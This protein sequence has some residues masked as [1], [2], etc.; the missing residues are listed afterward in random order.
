MNIKEINQL[1]EN[2][3]EGNKG[4]VS[5]GSHTFDELYFHRMTLFAVICNSHKKLAWKSWKHDDGTM[6]D[7]YFIVGVET[8]Q[9]QYTYHYQSEHWNLFAVKELDFAPR[10][11]GH[12]ASD[13]FRLFSIL[14]N[15]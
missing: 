14:D 13:I 10:W 4:G 15:K 2:L 5:D 3:G 7:D 6:F 12:Q 11:D 1:I 9:G 8:P